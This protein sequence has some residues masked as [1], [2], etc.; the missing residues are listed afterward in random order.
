M[1]SAITQWLSCAKNREQALVFES[2]TVLLTFQGDFGV[3]PLRAGIL[4]GLADVEGLV[5]YAKQ[6]LF[7]QAAGIASFL[8]YVSKWPIVMK[9]LARKS[10]VGLPRNE[11]WLWMDPRSEERHSSYST[12]FHRTRLWSSTALVSRASA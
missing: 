5:D 12:C 6:L 10:A 1:H 3:V 2:S 9:W 8:A 7:V 4:S 11:L